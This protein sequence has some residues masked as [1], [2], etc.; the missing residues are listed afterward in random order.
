M[1]IALIGYGRMG[2]AIEVL[3]QQAGDT[4]VLRQEINTP[5][6]EITAKLKTADVAI[7]FSGPAGAYDNIIR[8]LRSGVPVVSG[9]TGWLDRREE[10]DRMVVQTDGAF[11]YAANFSIGVQLF[12][13][14]NRYLAQLMNEQPAYQPRVHEIHHTA[15]K[16]APSGTAIQAAE[17]LLAELDRTSQW[18]RGE[19]ADLSVL[20]VTSERIDPTPGTHTIT[21]QSSIDQIQLQHVAHSREGFAQGALQ[22]AQW[23]VGK[24]GSF[25]MRDMLGF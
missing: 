5:N 4:I 17:E 15:K 23:L 19:S 7:E 2:K 6:D 10:V 1:R 13:A 9:S 22:A 16:D 14:V 12:F 21:F 25:G 11:F 18:V 8:C 3:A 24:T 20:P